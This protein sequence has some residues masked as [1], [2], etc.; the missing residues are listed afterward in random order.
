MSDKKIGLIAATAIVAGNMMGSGIALLPASLAKIGSITLYAWI[1]CSIGAMCLAF[2]FARL[3]TTNPQSG[4]PVAYAGEVAPI[5]GYQSGVLY[6]HSNWIGNLAI[7]VTGVSYLAVFFPLFKET[8]PASVASIVAVWLFCLVNLV[9]ANFIG[10]LVTVGVT[11]LL[12]PIVLT[13]TVGWA[14][15]DSAQFTANW[16]V[17]GDK[18]NFQALISAVILCIWAFVGLESASVNAGLVKNPKRT[19]PMS[20]MIGTF[21][22]AVVYILSTSAMM[23]MYPA[24]TLAASGAPFSDA[25]QKMSGMAIAAKIVSAVTAFACFASLGSWMMLTAEA[26]ARTA[27][28]GYFPKIYG[29]RTAGGTPVK[30]L[31]LE[32]IQM[33]VLMTILMVLQMGGE[34]NSA[35]LFGKI[36]SIAVLTVLLPYLYSCLN[37]IAHTGLKLE[38]LFQFMASIVAAIFCLVA[39]YGAKGEGLAEAIIVSLIILIFYCRWENEHQEK[40]LNIPKPA[41]TSVPYKDPNEVDL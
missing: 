26:G 28:D 39:L 15:F 11:L 41:S 37:L 24:E 32:A 21:L 4:G 27:N 30:G 40:G 23:G 12:I 14:F 5:L 10:K 22:A 6:Y 13:A 25:A 3:G 36:A 2:V 34:G 9:G 17:T 16:N 33:T 18:S 8:I 29:Q 35:D 7:A 19:V 31:I 38:Q 20:T 1:L